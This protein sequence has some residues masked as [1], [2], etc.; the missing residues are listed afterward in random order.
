MGFLTALGLARNSIPV[1]LLEAGPAIAE[2]PRAAVYFPTTVKVLDQLGVLDDALTIGLKNI[3]FCFR[4]LETGE[5]VM[6]DT[7]TSMP[8]EERYPY[9]L[10]FGQHI[11]AGIV[12]DHLTR[13]ADAQ[14][15][16]NHTVVDLEQNGSGVTLSV[17]TPDGRKEIR[18]DWVVGADG[19]NSSVRRLLGLPFDGHTWPDRFVATN[20]SYPF[21]QYGFAPANM[22]ADPVNW[23]VVAR[24]GRENLWRVTYGEDASLPEGEVRRRIPDHY[25][26][27][28]PSQDE[29]YEIVAASPYR[30]HER[31]VPTF[32][33]GR[34]LLAGDAAHV[35]N[36]CGGMGLTSGVI[37][38]K[39]LAQVLS[40]VIL[41][42]AGER[43]LGFYSEERRRV[44]HEVTSPVATEFKRRLSEKDPEKR[45]AD[46]RIFREIAENPKAAP[47]SALLSAQI[48]GRPMPV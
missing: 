24:L 1:T 38:A 19:A 37:D 30:V 44:F 4:V 8:P 14:V 25:R 47:Q 39:A 7:T 11:L 40:A 33:D 20:V 43:V 15:W 42:K 22:V 9:N 6:V 12:M 46:A 3:Y 29:M 2:S 31:C 48:E 32:R 18:S 41:G 45:R 28:M 17:D 16:F 13:I 34:V 21:D 36:P 10:H 27:I 35:C 26:A 5:I 23:A